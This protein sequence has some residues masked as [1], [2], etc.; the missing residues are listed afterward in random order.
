MAPRERPQRPRRPR[1]HWIALALAVVV[2]LVFL[3]VLVFS[4]SWT[5]RPPEPVT[6]ELYAPP[7]KAAVVETPPPRPKPEPAPE[8]KVEP[9]PAALPPEPKVE[10]R[11]VPKP[12]PPAPVVEKPDPRAAD[13][14]L[15]ARQEAERKQKEAQKKEQEKKEAEAKKQDDKRQADLRE[16][17]EREVAALRRE[18]EKETQARVQTDREN[19]FREQANRELQENARKAA[20]QAAMAARSKA[21]AEWVDR[22]RARVRSNVIEPPDLAGSPEAIFLVV[23]LPTG[24]VIDVQL[25]KTSGMRAYD[26]AVSRAILKSSPLPKPERAEVFQRTLELRFRPER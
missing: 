25:K 9:K 16:R 21:E 3:G 7:T 20:Q 17:Q 5:N 14:A 24:E 18:A 13:I 6:A 22:I 19:Q 1:G 8:P 23:L 15:K 12:Q 2:N 11:P 4:V 10:P 26:D